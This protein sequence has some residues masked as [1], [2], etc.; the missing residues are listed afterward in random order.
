[1]T[2]SIAASKDTYVKGD[3]VTISGRLVGRPVGSRV[4]LQ[5]LTTSG[6][7]KNLSEARTTRSG[8]AFPVRP[9]A[10]SR[11]TY[12]VLTQQGSRSSRVLSKNVVIRHRSCRAAPRPAVP[13]EAWFN[14]ASRNDGSVLSD[15]LVGLV[16]AAERGSTIR[17]TLYF[18]S[19]FTSRS[20][21][22]IEALR[23]VA[24]ERNVRVA[25]IV[26][27][28]HTTK[29]TIDYL[30]RFASV[31]T[32]VGGCS[33]NGSSDANTHDKL[34]AISDTTW[35]KGIMPV[36][37]LSSAN[38]TARQL[39][40]YWQSATAFYGDEDLYAGQVARWKRLKACGAGTTDA[41]REHNCA[42]VADGSPGWVRSQYGAWGLT[43]DPI[44]RS[45]QT[46]GL[47]FQFF[48]A[49]TSRDN[50]LELLTRIGCTPGAGGEIRVAMYSVS[51]WRSP[52]IS[53]QLAR[54]KREGCRVRLV[55]STG[56]ATSNSASVLKAFSTRGLPPQCVDLMHMKFAVYRNVT[57]DG[58][59]GQT[60]VTDGSQN[61]DM[62]GL[63]TNDDTTFSL[64]TLGLDDAARGWVSRLAGAYAD[65]WARTADHPVGCP[66]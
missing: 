20:A 24:E 66:R 5:R 30:R 51:P 16:C 18:V 23:F 46:A 21:D 56:G 60:I 13:Y 52:G 4:V 54:L 31:S 44:F 35:T 43:G 63:R 57:L 38:W 41:A 61:W 32:C 11:L 48:P 26:D 6:A 29:S 28:N 9:A 49:T 36:A 33:Y 17:V 40:E 55:L 12:R 10:A 58:V 47:S 19:A 27:R 62:I 8:Y 1:M 3:S 64:S 2:V 25:L 7:W 37:V 50:V 53:T 15:H 59:A 14:D 65:A 22:I 42:A 45:T 34:L 39:D